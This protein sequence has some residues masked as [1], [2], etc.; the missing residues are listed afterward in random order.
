MSRGPCSA[1]T[2]EYVHGWNA[3]V[4]AV[5][6]RL[7]ADVSGLLESRTSQEVLDCLLLVL[8][9]LRLSTAPLPP[10]ARV[11][12]SAAKSRELRK[13]AGECLV[14]LSDRRMSTEGMVEEAV[15]LAEGLMSLLEKRGHLRG[16]GE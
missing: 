1:R 7:R 8:G 13:V 16:L 9:K 5:Q 4:D 10:P 11:G 6:L 12:F 14:A 3:A 2:P 15:N